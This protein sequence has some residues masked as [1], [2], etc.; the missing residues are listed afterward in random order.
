MKFYGVDTT[1]AELLAAPEAAQHKIQFLGASDTA[2]YCVNGLPE[3]GP[4]KNGPEGWLYENCD[5]GYVSQVS[6]ALD[7]DFE[8]H[9][10]AGIGLTQNASANQQWQLGP[11]TLPDY[12]PR[13]MESDPENPWDPSKFVPDLVI[14]S[15][16][17][18]DYNH[19]NGNVPSDEEFS[20][21]YEN[22][23]QTIF[24]QY[25]SQ[26]KIVAICG[27]G[28]PTE[29]A[30]DPDNNR[31]KPCPHVEEAVTAFN[32]LYTGV[33]PLV[34]YIFIPCDGTVVTGVDDIGCAGHKNQIG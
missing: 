30:R 11:L 21:A 33:Y 23:L 28:D 8:V 29:A 22:F 18:N 3:F 20:A 34:D 27:M 6:Q 26:N 14:V 15:L 25:D 13:T 2:G 4:I 19:Q 1:N 32:E 16:G 24:D 12:Y 7:A 5:K 17:G 10:I 9:A 31:C